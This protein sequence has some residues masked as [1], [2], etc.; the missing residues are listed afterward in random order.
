MSKKDNNLLSE[1]YNQIYSNVVEEAKKAKKD[2]DGDGKVES[3]QDEYKGSKDKAIKGAMHGKK[4]KGKKKVNE[5][6]EH[7]KEATVALIEAVRFLAKKDKK[8]EMM[9]KPKRVTTGTGAGEG[10]GV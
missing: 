6:V 3:P 7:L 5:Q 8:K 1:A 2:Y 4:G 10:T 9:K